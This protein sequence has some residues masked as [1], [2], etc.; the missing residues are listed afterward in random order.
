M[1]LIDELKEKR[2]VWLCNVALHDQRVVDE[3]LNASRARDMVADLDRAIAALEPAPAEPDLF[4]AEQETASEQLEADH[5]LPPAADDVVADEQPEP[6]EGY[7]PVT[8]PEADAMARAHDYYSPQAVA[9]RT[10]FNPFGMFRRE[11]E[12]A[13]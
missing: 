8:N 12:D 1:A 6:V 7:A 4:E 13:L 5:A 10:K 9:E 2:E 11:P 3:C